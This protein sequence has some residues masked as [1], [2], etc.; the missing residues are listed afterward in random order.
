MSALVRGVQRAARERQLHV[1]EP[2]GHV[3]ERTEVQPTRELEP[4][5]QRDVD[6]VG[7]GLGERA[8]AARRSA[9]RRTR[10]GSRR[11]PSPWRARRS[12]GSGS[13]RSSS[14]CARGPPAPA[15]TRLSS[16]LRIAYDWLSKR[17]VVTSRSSRAC[18]QSDCSVYIALPSAC[19]DHDPPVGA[20]DR[21]T[22]GERHPL[23]DRAAG[24]R[25]P[26]VRRAAGG[27]AGREQAAGLRLVGD[28]RAFGHAS[29]RA[30]ARRRPR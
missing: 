10:A 25:Q 12:R 15:P 20:R 28:D 9:P 14:D 21:G 3:R 30:R 1:I 13:M 8:L 23:A 6:E 24:E 4:R 18:V 27:R 22:G 29:R 16:M 7:A 5:G 19:S 26:V 11:R 17:I 2:L